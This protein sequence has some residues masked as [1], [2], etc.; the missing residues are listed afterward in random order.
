MLALAS[1]PAT[2]GLRSIGQT[3]WEATAESG[4]PEYGEPGVGNF[5]QVNSGTLERSN[6]DLADEMVSLLSAQR[7]YQANARA[8]DTATQISQTVLNLRS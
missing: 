8:I 4:T 3:K 1:F 6:V 7:N 5:G 2:S